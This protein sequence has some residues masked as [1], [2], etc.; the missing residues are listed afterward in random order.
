[1]FELKKIKYKNIKNANPYWVLQLEPEYGV[2][3]V[4]NGK[5][6]YSAESLFNF[7]NY[8]NADR[9]ISLFHDQNVAD[10]LHLLASWH[11]SYLD[12]CKNR[13][14]M[15]RNGSFIPV[16]NNNEIEIIETKKI[17][18]P[19]WSKNNFFKEIFDSVT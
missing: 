10:Y 8:S 2:D 6:G 17:D 5:F 11:L 4:S 15:W 7:I 19:K 3:N 1:M 12:A 9:S 13:F 18:S 16:I 14:C